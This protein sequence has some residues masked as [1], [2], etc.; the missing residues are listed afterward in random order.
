MTT[1]TYPNSKFVF[2]DENG[3]TGTTILPESITTPSITVSSIV[4]STGSTGVS[5]Y[6]L[7]STGDGVKWITPFVSNATS[8]LNM[9]NNTITNVTTLTTN[10]LNT[11]NI[12]GNTGTVT[13]TNQVDFKVAPTSEVVPSQPNHISTKSYADSTILNPTIVNGN[14]HYIL[15]LNTTDPSGNILSDTRTQNDGNTIPISVATTPTTG[16]LLTTFNSKQIGITQIP[17]CVW[18]LNLYSSISN[19]VNAFSLGFKLY[20]VTNGTPSLIGTSCNAG[21]INSSPVGYPFLNVM[22]LGMPTTKLTNI[23]DTLRLEIYY[24]RNTGT[25]ITGEVNFEGP[26]YSYL[27]I[28]VNNPLNYTGNAASNLNMN[29]YNIIPSGDLTI[30]PTKRSTVFTIDS[31]TLNIG[32]GNGSVN[33]LYAGTTGTISVNNAI[34][35]VYSTYPTSR[36]LGQVINVTLPTPIFFPL[37]TNNQPTTNTIITQ[38]FT[39]PYTGIWYTTANAGINCTI[40]AGTITNISISIF[41][42]TKSI[43]ICNQTITGTITSSTGLYNILN[44]GGTIIGSASD[45]IQL[46]QTITYTD[47]SNQATYSSSTTDFV[48]NFVRV[49]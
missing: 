44:C 43:T 21:D 13:F 15:Y 25:T 39:L 45:T 24:F 38:S 5:G 30:T 31:S 40:A 23:T 47:D 27:N 17:P 34:T 2:T 29:N 46:L 9:N 28:I 22:T 10:T 41:N 20:L 37:T 48:W 49:G 26:L 32:S 19:I 12:T 1:I 18:Q 6:V 3:N 16:T 11:T 4:D 35:P 14:K 7:S 42:F 8:N 36:H 33:F